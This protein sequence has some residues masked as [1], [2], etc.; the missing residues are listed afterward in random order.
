GFIA[1]GLTAL[2]VIYGYHVPVSHPFEAMLTLA[3]TVLCATVLGGVVGALL[4]RTLV[5]TPLILGITLPFYLDSGALEPQRFDGEKLF[6]FSHLSPTYYAVGAIEHAFHSLV[7]T[8]ES[9]PLLLGV[10]IL[11]TIASLPVLGM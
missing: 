4:K 11:A 7:V 10:L 8:P 5:I 9:V 3:V 6:W 2:V 1:S